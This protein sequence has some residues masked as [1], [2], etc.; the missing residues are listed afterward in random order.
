MLT[1]SL[2]LAV[3]AGPV[4]AAPTDASGPDSPSDSPSGSPSGSPSVAVPSTDASE[5]V[6]ASTEGGAPD[7]SPTGVPPVA[8]SGVVA[9]DGTATPT[10]PFGVGVGEPPLGHGVEPGGPIEGGGP[11]SESATPSALAITTNS[12]SVT[13][14]S[15]WDDWASFV[16]LAGGL[17]LVAAVGWMWSRPRGPAAAIA[18]LPPGVSVLPEAGLFGPGTPSLSNGIFLW[19]TEGNQADVVAPLVATLA[20]YHRVLFVAA[21]GYE[22]P[23]VHGGPVFH[24]TNLDAD[25]VAD[26]AEALSGEGG[27]PVAVVI[28]NPRATKQELLDYAEVA[29]AGVGGVIFVE[30]D[31]D[32]PLTKLRSIAGGTDGAGWTFR[33]DAVELTARETPSGFA[34]QPGTVA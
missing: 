24:T 32:V 21:E 23:R 14:K 31:A 20:T 29:P 8:G 18:A 13:K 10:P 1:L 28:V 26:S 2:F 27:A 16:A 6:A 12:P 7:P 15:A 34:V 5:V 19:I 33:V 22:V 9:A 4:S 30:Q 25:H 3:F 11:V 17:V